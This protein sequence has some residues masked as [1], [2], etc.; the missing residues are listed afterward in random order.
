[1]SLHYNANC[2]HRARITV[3]TWHSSMS[4]QGKDSILHMA[5]LKVFTGQ[6]QLNSEGRYN[7]LH[8]AKLTVCTWQNI[9]GKY[10]TD[11]Y[12]FK[13]DRL[14]FALDKNGILK[15]QMMICTRQRQLSAH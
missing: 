2:I 12:N 5:N 4:S 13:Q 6:A 8:T 10:R 3:L 11:K 9:Q 1:M 15:L 14:L 7:C